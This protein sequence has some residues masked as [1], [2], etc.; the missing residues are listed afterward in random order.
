M[1]AGQ[2]ERTATPASQSSDNI[3]GIDIAAKTTVPFQGGGNLWNKVSAHAIQ[4]ELLPP[5]HPHPPGGG[6][7]PGSGVAPAGRPTRNPGDGPA[8]RRLFLPG[9]QLHGLVDHQGD[10][11]RPGV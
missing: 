5:I 7:K 3:R 1:P 6:R 4:V 9:P 11:P 8:P 2:G 10:L